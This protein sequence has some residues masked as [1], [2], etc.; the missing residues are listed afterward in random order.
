MK[1]IL[2]LFIFLCFCL[3]LIRMP[4]QADPGYMYRDGQ[5][6]L[7][8]QA[9]VTREEVELLVREYG[10]TILQDIPLTRDYLIAFDR[11]CSADELSDR[12]NALRESPLTDRISRNIDV[13]WQ[14]KAAETL[15]NP[16]EQ[17]N[18]DSESWRDDG[19]CALPYGINWWAEALNLQDAWEITDASGLSTVSVGIYDHHIFTAN[20]DVSVSETLLFYDDSELLEAESRL[21]DTDIYHG[22]RTAAILS[23]PANREGIRGV[24]PNARIVAVSSIGANLLYANARL[25]TAD[26]AEITERMDPRPAESVCRLIGPCLKLEGSANASGIQGSDD[27]IQTNL[28]A[29]E[30]AIAEMLERGVKVI[31]ISMGPPAE[32]VASACFDSRAG[33]TPENSQALRELQDFADGFGPF[34]E[35]CEQQYPDF[36]FIV[37]SGNENGRKYRKTGNGTY[38]HQLASV[39]GSTATDITADYSFFGYLRSRSDAAAGHIVVVGSL[40]MAYTVDQDGLSETGKMSLS[41]SS[42]STKNADV[43]APGGILQISGGK[44]KVTFQIGTISRENTIEE[45]TGTSY[46]TSMVSGIAAMVW[47]YQPDLSYR[48]VRE[49]LVDSSCSAYAAMQYTDLNVID[50]VGALR[51]ADELAARR[52]I[53]RRSDPVGS[54]GYYRGQLYYTDGNDKVQVSD[55]TIRI[56]DENWKELY[57]YSQNQHAGFDIMLP[58]GKYHIRARRHLSPGGWMQPVNNLRDQEYI[59]D[60]EITDNCIRWDCAELKP[61]AVMMLE[62][63][64]RKTV[65]RGAFYESC[66]DSVTT[67]TDETGEFVPVLET[68]FV[69]DLA[70]SGYQAEKP[71]EYH[72]SGAA[73]TISVDDSYFGLL[74]QDDLYY[75][76]EYQNGRTH[77]TTYMA[78]YQ[79]ADNTENGEPGTY[80]FSRIQADHL[81]SVSEI[82]EY[83]FTVALTREQ[84]QD[85]NVPQWGSGFLNEEISADHG[86]LLVELNEDMSLLG[87]CIST[88]GKSSAPSDVPWY[89]NTGETLVERELYY[90]FSSEP[91]NLMDGMLEE[92]GGYDEYDD[93][94]LMLWLLPLL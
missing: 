81:K 29:Y 64:T 23:A 27:Y 46:A 77:L 3:I 21:T 87:L 32:L 55:C 88:G 66:F 22:T 59:G 28:F 74:A 6:I 65:S 36:L 72:A 89:L 56:F 40:D 61:A 84:L 45:V 54:R 26:R 58:P 91:I 17:L 20:T 11:D 83:S 68:A 75:D 18:R 69:S 41:E 50:A 19:G 47:G 49:C 92:S 53:S 63:G 30:Y 13:D 43:Y 1:R 90:F 35:R 15:S 48:E 7:T 94:D 44:K 80:D 31:N 71:R 67:S 51:K 73:C 2:L 62:Y 37:S 10:G 85:L 33:C 39:I 78:G 42:F 60:F 76:V 38:S 52:G 8:A 4:A 14:I 57:Q 82:D 25:E 70:I 93:L 9:G 12:A 24:A 86:T 79:I 5:L 16:A 34:I